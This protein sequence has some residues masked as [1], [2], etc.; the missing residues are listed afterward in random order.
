MSP[1]QLALCSDTH[2]WFGTDHRFGQND[3]QLQPWSEQIQDTLLS[4]LKMSSPDIVCHLGDVTCGGG[5]YLMPDNDFYHTLDQVLAGFEAL[6]ADTYFLPGNHDCPS[7]AENWRHFEQRV[8]LGAALGNTIDL[9]QARIILLNAQGHD[10]QQMSQA[11]PDDPIYGW[12]NDAELARLD[13]ALGS[14]GTKPVLLFIHQVLQPWD[15]EQEWNDM[16]GINNAA[17]VITVL[18]KHRNVRAV[19]Q[20]HA[21]RLDVQQRPIGGQPC[22]FVVQPAL[23]EYPLAW[24]HLAL[25]ETQISVSL[26]KLPLESLAE[27]SLAC[28]P[29]HH[30]R[31]GQAAWHN[32]EIAL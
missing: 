23:I 17:Q 16:Y 14:A 7:G 24:L 27:M 30:W 2:F 11:A 4:E 19:F 1:I 8:G 28:N 13:E 32:F 18:E 22:T 5:G 15:G 29:D 9:P 20:A 10:A 31:V 26:K 12:V 21:H 25:S 6:P 3:S